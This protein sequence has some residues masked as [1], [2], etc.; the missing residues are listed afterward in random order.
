LKISEYS[1][2]DSW[3]LKDSEAF[4]FFKIKTMSAIIKYT[5]LQNRAIMTA[6]DQLLNPHKS[7]QKSSQIS[8]VYQGQPITLRFLEALGWGGELLNLGYF[9]HSGLTNVLNLIPDSQR[10]SRAQRKL[11]EKAVALLKTSESDAVLDVA[12]GRGYASKYL[13]SY[14]KKGKV[15]GLDLLPENI[16]Q[17][18][19]RFGSVTNCEF[20]L[21][22]ACSM[23]FAKDSFQKI[24]CLEAAFHFPSRQTF[25]NEAHRVLQKHGT[26]VVV[27]FM[28]KSATRAKVANHPLVN[29]VKKTWAWSD[30]SSI[31]EYLE[32]IANSGFELVARHDW[33]KKVTGALQWQFNIVAKLAQSKAG[34]DLLLKTNPSLARF[35][36]SEWQEIIT[37]AKAHDFVNSHSSYMA[38]V[39]KKK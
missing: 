13:A 26:M 19:T 34:R 7:V 35:K 23:P 27:D 9:R 30:F 36:P 39:V 38:L 31:N 15:I 22:D 28:W 10:L 12:C 3:V 25:L 21:G 29:I 1:P 24:L 16:A 18:R 33:T 17:G 8:L 2:L 20:V 5:N 32:M 4:A 6:A 37:A 14:V 11:V